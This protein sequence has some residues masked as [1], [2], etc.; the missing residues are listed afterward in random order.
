MK[1]NVNEKDYEVVDTA[2]PL[3]WALRDVL[4]MT[5]T[6]YSCGIGICGCCTVLADNV[7]IRSCITL[8]SEIAGKKITTIEGLSADGTHKLQVAWKTVDVAQCGFCQPGQIM[9]AAG[10]LLD[11]P[12]PTDADIDNYMHDN[13]CRCGTYNRIREAIHLASS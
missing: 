9:N 8:V 4:G 12:K 13:I 10:L 11:N 1:I 5:G 2:M 7:P 6:K 3:L